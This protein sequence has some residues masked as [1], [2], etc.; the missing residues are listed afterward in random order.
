MNIDYNEKIYRILLLAAGLIIAIGTVFYHL[1]EHFKWLD[2]Y[3]FS[4]VT[5]AT[6]GYGDLVPKTD[7][8]KLFTTFY[9][10]AGVGIITTFIT[11]TVRKRAAH[12][13]EK[14]KEKAPRE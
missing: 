11:Y 2:A 12:R 6:V 4:V 8:G 5:L 1:V 3:Y 7:A 9:I 14:H 10:L 13:V